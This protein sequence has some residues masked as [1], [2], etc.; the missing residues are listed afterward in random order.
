MR[1]LSQSEYGEIRS[2]YE[3][4]YTP[5]VDEELELSDEEL[6]EAVEDAVFELIE[7]G[8]DID[9]IECAFDDELIEEILD[10]AKITYGSDTESP[11]ERRTR[12]KAKVGEKR[13]AARKAAVKGAVKAAGENA[14]EVKSEVGRR[15]GNVAVRA[16]AGATK[17]AMKATGVSPMDVPTKAGK[18]RKSADTFVAGRKADRDSAKAVIK[19]KVGDKYRGAKAA[20]GIAGSIA[21]DEARKAG[22]KAKLAGGKAVTAVKNAPEK[23]GSSIRSKL[24]ATKKGIKSRIAS[25]LQKVS[26]KAGSAAKRMSEEV[27]TYNVVVEFL[28]DYGIAEDLQ[29]AQ[30]LMVNEIDSEDIESILEAY[31]NAKLPLSREKKTKKVDD[32]KEDPNRDFGVRGT[33][34]K[35]LA[36][37]ATTVVGTQRRQDKDAGLR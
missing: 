20:A 1:A 33:A 3:S 18:Q 29:E 4:I 21:K 17:T 19:K 26:D 14:K 10:E 31:A 24:S 28:C 27:E 13:S 11:E 12:A 16:K 23:A 9:D 6:T 7:E 36:S 15:A 22:R 34:A 37:R 2:L 32:W 30:W 8:Y 5:Q 35:N 25:G